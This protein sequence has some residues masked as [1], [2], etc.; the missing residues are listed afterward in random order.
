MVRFH[1]KNAG[2]KTTA[3]NQQGIET[4][5]GLSTLVELP[6]MATVFGDDLAF[7]IRALFC[8]AFGPNLRNSVAHGLLTGPACQTTQVVYAWWLCLRLVFTSYWNAQRAQHQPENGG[9]A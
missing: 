8:D 3:L 7:E 4:E 5:N 6:E 1:L 9:E 2:A